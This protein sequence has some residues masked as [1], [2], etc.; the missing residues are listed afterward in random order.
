MIGADEEVSAL[1]FI[2][3]DTHPTSEVAE[4]LE[5]H[6]DDLYHDKTGTPDSE[7]SWIGITRVLMSAVLTGQKSR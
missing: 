4:F 3:R 5:E 1:W 7:E 2:P 6:M